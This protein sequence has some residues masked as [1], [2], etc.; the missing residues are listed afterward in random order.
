MPVPDVMNTSF[1]ASGSR[2]CTVGCDTELRANCVS[3]LSDTVAPCEW[4]HTTRRLQPYGRTHRRGARGAFEQHEAVTGGR[5]KHPLKA[6]DRRAKSVTGN[7]ADH[8]HSGQQ[9]DNERA[10]SRRKTART[11]GHEP[12]QLFKLPSGVSPT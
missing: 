3:A 4:A 2:S 10:S 1:E 6:S 12:H 7:Q 11:A 9:H 8:S 5:G